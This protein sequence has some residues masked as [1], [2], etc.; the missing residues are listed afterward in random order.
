MIAK[1][2][3]LI[4]LNDKAPF[5]ITSLHGDKLTV[6]QHVVAWLEQRLPCI[7]AKQLPND[8]MLHLGLPLFWA[9]KRHRIGLSVA[10]SSVEKRQTLPQL[11]D[12]VGY[13]QSYY[14]LYDIQTM[15]VGIEGLDIGVYGSFLF[16]YLSGIPCINEQSDVDLLITYQGETLAIFTELIDRLSQS[17]QRTID[18]EVRF[19][20]IGDVS[21]KE[22]LDLSAN[23]LLCKNCTGIELIS[24]EE[25]YE[26]Y[27]L[28]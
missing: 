3:D 8:G 27:S 22:L 23:Q 4:Y 7:Y 26:H 28:L 18:G 11:V 10:P 15:L 24:R 6:D 25:L 20:N 5:I 21:I 16:H 2:H 1:R 9:N 12:M 13:F 17:L 14:K 19:K